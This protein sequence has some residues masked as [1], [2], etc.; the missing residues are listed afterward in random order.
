M[1]LRGLLFS[2]FFLVVW[3]ASP[4]PYD[5]LNCICEVESNCAMPNPPCRMDVGSLSCGPFQIKQAY[6]TDAKR[7]GGYLMGS[8]SACTANWGCSRNAVQAYMTRYAT[9]G[10]L[11]HTP[12]CEDF[13][14]IHNGGPNGF[15]K[16]GTVAYWN[17]VRACL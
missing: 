7:H 14:R 16:S 10:R 12:R 3:G 6:W 15:Q 8:W 5:C 2:L 17:K 4:V 9:V 1:L 13:A 11:G